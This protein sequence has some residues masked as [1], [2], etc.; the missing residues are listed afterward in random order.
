L[1]SSSLRGLALRPYQQEAVGK[2]I[3]AKHATIKAPTATGKT[4]IAMAWLDKVGTEALV[5]VPTQ[6]LIYQSWAPKL[7]K[8]GFRDVGTYYACAKRFGSITLTTFSSAMSHPDLIDSVDTVVVDEIHHLGARAALMRLLP[9]LKEKEFVL[10]LS[11]VPEREDMTH[12]FF[13]QE[14]P[15]CYD[16]SLAEAFEKG[17]VSPIEV[18]EAPSPMNA[19]ERARYEALTARIK[20][21]FRHCG[22]NLASWRNC[23]D[24]K[25]KRYVGQQGVRSIVLRKGLLSDVASK[26]ETVLRIV[27]AHPTDRILLFSESVTAIEKTRKYLAEN[28]VAC[29]AFHSKIEPWRRQEILE[30]WGHRFLVLLS[31]RALEEGM[32]VPEVAV[33]I[34]VTNGTSKRQY[35]QRI[36]RIIRPMEGKKAHFY[37]VYSPNSVEE[38]YSRTIAKLLGL[39]N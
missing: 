26:R 23:Y 6:A 7:T 39:D 1:S 15:I 22:N 5:I 28:K 16:L 38:R 2:A 29:E 18:V 3:A 8:Y 4:V 30:D 17:Y 21:A 10:G 34:L 27:R 37:V 13:L 9:K 14:F 12:E 32:D 20:D 19:R 24:P 35:I 25:T 33:G 36:G 11:S 31:C